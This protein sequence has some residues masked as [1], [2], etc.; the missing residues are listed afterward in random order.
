MFQISHSSNPALPRL[1]Y[2]PSDRLVVFHADD[3]GLTEG[4][5]EAFL[6]L[7]EA[8]IVKCGSIMVPCAHGDEM[9]ALAR[10]YPELDLG[11]HLTVVCEWT[12]ARWGPILARHHVPD[13]CMPDGSFWPDQPTARK[14]AGRRSLRREILAQMAYAQAAGLQCT[15]L[16]SHSV[17]GGFP[18]LTMFYIALGFHYGI[19]VLFPRRAGAQIR[20]YMP[21]AWMARAWEAL[22]TITETAGM[23]LVDHH[24]AT[25]FRPDHPRWRPPDLALA[26][27]RVL[28]HLEPGITYFSLHPNTAAYP[29]HIRPASMVFRAFEHTYFQSA[30]AQDFLAAQGIISI[31]MR[32]L[33]DIMQFSASRPT[34]SGDS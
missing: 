19:P 29:G 25:L 31:G 6:D 7:Q 16:D 14:M 8:G 26:Y 27:E 34:R 4:S 2:Q 20:P 5:I 22:A 23:P 13:L 17:K 28:A 10:L 12:R 1:G 32:E 33:R 18:E 24:R 9:L 15:H 21:A 30:R 11:I 3:L